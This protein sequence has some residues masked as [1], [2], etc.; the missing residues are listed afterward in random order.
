[1]A[2]SRMFV[3]GRGGG[4][5]GEEYRLPAAY[6]RSAKTVMPRIWILG[7]TLIGKLCHDTW[8]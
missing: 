7:F 1:M 3:L 6:A 4:G 8:L 2:S 5:G